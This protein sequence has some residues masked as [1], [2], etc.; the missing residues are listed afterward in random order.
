MAVTTCDIVWL[1]WFLADMGVHIS[2]PTPLYC[3]NISAMK[4]AKNLV[5]HEQT[6]HLEIDCHFTRHHLQP[7]T[8]S[9]L[10]FISCLTNSQCLLPLYF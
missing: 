6:K 2:H 5:F 7:G 8:I 9:R 10:G 3:D 1:R 4:I